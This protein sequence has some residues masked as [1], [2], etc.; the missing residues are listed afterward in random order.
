MKPKLGRQDSVR[1]W[2]IR[3]YFSKGIKRVRIEEQLFPDIS[4]IRNIRANQREL[5]GIGLPASWRDRAY[6]EREA[7]TVERESATVGLIRSAF[8]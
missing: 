2:W 4:G 1:F 6:R 5:L 7:E 3:R 8:A